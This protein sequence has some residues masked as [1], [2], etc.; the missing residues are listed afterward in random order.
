MGKSMAY[1]YFYD[2]A[3]QTDGA[4]AIMFSVCLSVCV[5]MLPCIHNMHLCTHLGGG[6]DRLAVWFDSECT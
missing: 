6:I 2:S 1:C 4:G 3:H 5:C